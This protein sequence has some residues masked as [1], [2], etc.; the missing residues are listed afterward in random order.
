MTEEKHPA[1]SKTLLFGAGLSALGVLA[2]SSEE[3]AQLV[4][5]LFGEE[6][7]A[8]TISALGLVTMVLRLIT[9]SPVSTSVPFAGR[10][11]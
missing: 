10:G 3:V 6:Y 5:V 11:R 1:R 9:R 8:V 2:Q 4:A 7:R